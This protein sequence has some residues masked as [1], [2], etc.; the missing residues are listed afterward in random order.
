MG[1]SEFARLSLEVES[2]QTEHSLLFS[3]SCFLSSIHCFLS[4]LLMR[5]KAADRRQTLLQAA[6]DLFS[7]QGYDGTT[8]R[9]IAER[10]GVTEALLF[11][12]FRSKQELLRAVVEEL[13][14]RQIF[15]PHPTDLAALPVRAALGRIL[16]QYFDAF[17]ENR[18]CLKMMLMATL[19]DQD[20]FDQIKTQFGGQTLALYLFLRE[21]EAGG[22][23][24]PDSAGAITDVVSAATSGF[25]QRELAEEPEDWSAARSQF[26]ANLLRIMFEGAA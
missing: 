1:L 20:V 5:Q 12:H 17:W 4:S 18:A 26:T 2:W 24:Q 9:A 15:P 3:V 8:T 10:G 14:P 23:L 19:R 21:R 11:R 6:L 16:T 13:G 7:T 25:L 22:E